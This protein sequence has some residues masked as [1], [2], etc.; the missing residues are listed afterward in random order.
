MNRINL[1]AEDLEG[2]R[3][4]IQRYGSTAR[5][6]EILEQSERNSVPSRLSANQ[7]ERLHRSGVLSRQE[8]RDILG[9]PRRR[10]FG[11]R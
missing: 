9:V 7:V 5:A 1:T 6:L 11:W 8:A 4:I 2:L 3:I 10:L